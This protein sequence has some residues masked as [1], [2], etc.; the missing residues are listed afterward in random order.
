[1]VADEKV[2]VGDLGEA[3]AG[4]E[5]LRGDV[6]APYRKLHRIGLERPGFGQRPVHQR[7][8]DALAGARRVGVE[9]LQRDRP[10][11]VGM[12]GVRAGDLELAEARQR[13]VR[14]DR[15]AMAEGRIGDLA[16]DGLLVVTIGEEGLQVF[17]A[18]KMAE[19]ERDWAKRKLDQIDRPP[20]G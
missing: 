2:D 12:F 14:A 6:L 19:G 7:R 8:A 11:S 9:L 3:V 18:V 20:T 16:G 13:A 4:V 15:Q 1:M 10:H 17:G 5:A